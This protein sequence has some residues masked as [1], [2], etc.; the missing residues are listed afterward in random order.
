MMQT[1]TSDVIGVS[2][3][4]FIDHINEQLIPLMQYG[5]RDSGTIGP[6]FEGGYSV[7]LDMN[8]YEVLP[9][10]EIVGEF[11]TQE[12][13]TFRYTCKLADYSVATKRATFSVDFD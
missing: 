10:N 6:Y 3:S 9:L 12:E 7:K 5:E 4:E 13:E 2:E 8:D 11:I 1:K